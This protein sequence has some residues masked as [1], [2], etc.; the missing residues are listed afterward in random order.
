MPAPCTKGVRLL[1]LGC[2]G[3]CESCR[4]QFVLFRANVLFL[5]EPTKQNQEKINN[6]SRKVVNVMYLISPDDKMSIVLYCELRISPLK[7]TPP[8]LCPVVPVE[9]QS[10]VV[11]LML[12]SLN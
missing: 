6:L 3:F 5:L 12:R 9:N 1:L 11:F 4:V 8:V 2:L 10:P 7:I